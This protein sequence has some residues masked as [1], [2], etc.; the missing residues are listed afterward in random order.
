M[1]EPVD[2]L[3]ERV[4]TL[5]RCG[6]LPILLLTF[7][8]TYWIR[9]E[10][11]AG[12]D[13]RFGF[14]ITCA[15]GSLVF[16]SSACMDMR[17][18]WPRWCLTLS[19]ICAVACLHFLIA[20]TGGSRASL[21]A[22]LY[23]YVPV[24]VFMTSIRKLTLEIVSVALVL[25]SYWVNYT[26]PPSKEWW[27]FMTDQPQ[28]QYF[29]TGFTLVLLVIALVLNHRLERGADRREAPAR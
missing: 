9:L 2:D 14:A 13:I 27:L 6:Q 22:G 19:L 28:Y 17:T 25:L 29:E 16:S 24:V 20:L 7:G 11:D 15:V 21:Y 10:Y 12:Q 1:P 23:Y 8:L 5:F 4:Q 26:S 3:R 18:P